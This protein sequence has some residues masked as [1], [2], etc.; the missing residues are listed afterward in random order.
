MPAVV[1]VREGEETFA[2]VDVDVASHTTLGA[3]ASQALGDALPTTL[4][5]GAALSRVEQS[6]VGGDNFILRQEV[7]DGIKRH[8]STDS[9]LYNGCRV[10]LNEDT[11]ELWVVHEAVVVSFHKSNLPLLVISRSSFFTDC[12]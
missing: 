4:V 8:Y 2:T 9:L 1:R 10:H 5:K 3:I 11:G 7:E 6:F 12:L